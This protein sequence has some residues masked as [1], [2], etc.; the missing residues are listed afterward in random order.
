MVIKE[1]N[2]HSGWS[3]GNGDDQYDNESLGSTKGVLNLEKSMENSSNNTKNGTLEIIGSKISKRNEHTDEEYGWTTIGIKSKRKPKTTERTPLTEEIVTTNNNS[4]KTVEKEE[5]E[6]QIETTKKNNRYALPEDEE[7]NESKTN[8][9]EDVTTKG[10]KQSQGKQSEKGTSNKPARTSR[11]TETAERTRDEVAVHKNGTHEEEAVKDDRD[12]NGRSSRTEEQTTTGTQNKN[13]TE[14]IGVTTMAVNGQSE[15][16]RMATIRGT[17]SSEEESNQNEDDNTEKNNT[18]KTNN[19]Q[20]DNS[21]KNNEGGNRTRVN[22]LEPEDMNTYSF[23]V[24]WRPDQ[25][26]GQDGKVIIRMLM[27]EMVCRTPSITFH[28]T[29]ASTSPVPRDINNINNDFPKTPANYDNFFDQMINRD[30]TNQRTYMKVTMPHDEKELQRKLSNYLRHN[31]LYMNSPYIDD[32]TLEQIG[33]IENGHSRLVYRPTLEKKIKDGLKEVM[34]GDQLTP[35]QGAQIK[36]LSHPIR[37]T[38]HAQGNSKSRTTSKPSSMRRNSAKDSKI[39]IQTGHG[40]IINATGF[41]TGR[42]IQS[43]AQKFKP[44]FGVRNVWKNSSRN[45]NLSKHTPS[46]HHHALPSKRIQG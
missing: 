30:N 10:R 39:T 31:K 15:K 45:S 21:N 14:E 7:D 1:A 34:N 33:F 42:A 28:P 5:T 8:N 2:L 29:N 32:N 25:K 26:K 19:N 23:T 13:S 16:E 17:N 38:L 40:A 12:T 20:G 4:S 27:R 37:V 9:K 35:Q 36:E 22:I 41:V 44:I 3:Y 46:S 6:A 43:N 18:D 11:T 24:S